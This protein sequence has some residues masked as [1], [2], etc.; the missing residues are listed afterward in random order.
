MLGRPL[1][2]Y[3]S[4][5]TRE[6]HEKYIAFSWNP[7]LFFDGAKNKLHRDGSGRQVCGEWNL[8]VLLNGTKDDLS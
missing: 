3:H 8:D 7:N 1:F 5:D 4:Q 2:S 6:D